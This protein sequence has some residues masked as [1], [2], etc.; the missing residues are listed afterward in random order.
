L[1][2][3]YKYKGWFGIA[4]VYIDD[5]ESL[6]PNLCARNCFCEILLDISEAIYLFMLRNEEFPL[7][8]IRITGKL[9]KPIVGKINEN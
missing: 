4:P 5:A 8:P 7:F 2:I 1:K 9:N 3:E 6:E